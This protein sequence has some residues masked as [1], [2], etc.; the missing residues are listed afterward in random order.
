MKD[1]PD[2]VPNAAH[3]VLDGRNQL[4]PQGTGSTSMPRLLSRM[5]GNFQIDSVV[6]QGAFGVVYAATD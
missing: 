6:G 3:E 2:G 4:S 5:V 1:D